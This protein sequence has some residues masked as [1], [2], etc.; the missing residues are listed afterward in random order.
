MLEAGKGGPKADAPDLQTELLPKENRDG[1][2]DFEMLMLDGSVAD[3]V[4]A[5]AA[6]ATD[7][8]S[9]T[10]ILRRV[11]WTANY[12]FIAKLNEEIVIDSIPF[13]E[14][15]KVTNS[16]IVGHSESMRTM[17]SKPAENAANP[18]RE[19]KQDTSRR[20][21]HPENSKSVRSWSI[22]SKFQPER[23][24][25]NSESLSSSMNGSSFNASTTG[26]NKESSK[27]ILQINTIQDGFNSGYFLL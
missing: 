15:E 13:A 2:Q 19:S 20:K 25:I 16:S 14:A 12:V 3:I 7:Y 23:K 10:W 1:D 22:S 21:I 5:S 27:A 24:E 9:R 4:Y 17:Q 18:E 8:F 11:V 6:H 26:D